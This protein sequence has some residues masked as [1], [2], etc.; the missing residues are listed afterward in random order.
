[1]NEKDKIKAILGIIENI[2]YDEDVIAHVI[3]PEYSRILQNTPG[4]W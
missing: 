2:E 3:N 1:M 4:T